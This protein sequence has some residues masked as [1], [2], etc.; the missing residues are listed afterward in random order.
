M[1]WHVYVLFLAYFIKL[2]YDS[3]L[4]QIIAYIKKIIFTWSLTIKITFTQIKPSYNKCLSKQGYN[5][6]IRKNNATFESNTKLELSIHWFKQDKQQIYLWNYKHWNHQIKEAQTILQLP[7]CPKSS[8]P[9]WL[10]FS[11]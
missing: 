2:L 7:M 11:N 8:Q 10:W 6:E 5:W 9:L 3:L 1:L 4:K